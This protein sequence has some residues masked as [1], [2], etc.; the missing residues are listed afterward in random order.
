MGKTGARRSRKG[1]ALA[2]KSLIR[3][4]QEK[5]RRRRRRSASSVVS[6]KLESLR[7][8]IPAGGKGGR[9]GIAAPATE[10]LLQE[11]ADYILRLRAQVAVLEGLIQLQGSVS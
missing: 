5:R 2:S 1:S 4:E 6:Q 8:L 9:E 7:N 10:V 3:S 11:T